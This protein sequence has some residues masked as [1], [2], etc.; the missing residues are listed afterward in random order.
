[1]SYSANETS[2]K[3][4]LAFLGNLAGESQLGIPKFEPDIMFSHGA[5]PIYKL[6]YH[7]EDIC[8]HH[9]LVQGIKVT[10]CVRA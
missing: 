6:E 9:Q 4:E 1:M 2:G 3:D 8:R 7:A 10:S 5:S